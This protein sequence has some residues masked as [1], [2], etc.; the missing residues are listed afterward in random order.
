ML[1]LFVHVNH[2]DAYADSGLLLDQ[3]VYDRIWMKLTAYAATASGPYASVN[4]GLPTRFSKMLRPFPRPPQAR[5]A[6]TANCHEFEPAGFALLSCAAFAKPDDVTNDMFLV[7]LAHFFSAVLVG[8]PN[9]FLRSVLQDALLANLLLSALSAEVPHKHLPTDQF[10]RSFTAALN[11]YALSDM[12]TALRRSHWCPHTLSQEL[13]PL[14][15]AAR[16]LDPVLCREADP[17][18]ALSNANALDEQAAVDVS[19]IIREC[20]TEAST[21]ATETFAQFAASL[22]ESHWSEWYDEFGTLLNS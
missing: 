15:T 16:D 6:T 13:F 5:L 21:A 1:S 2:R 10:L 14:P 19:S 18:H 9:P 22:H 12:P 17:L 8:M 3:H 20:C 7:D 11:S 4:P